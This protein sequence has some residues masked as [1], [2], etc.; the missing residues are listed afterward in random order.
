MEAEVE[1]L[2]PDDLIFPN[3]KGH[4]LGHDNLVKRRFLPLFNRQPTV[5]R[6]NWH[7]LRHFAV[8]C[9]IEERL[10]PKTVQTFA[11][12]PRYR[13]PWT[14]TGTCSQ[15]TTTAKRWTRLP[16]DCSINWG[17]RHSE[18]ENVWRTE[19]FIHVPSM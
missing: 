7:G 11:G 12:M 16:K 9:W 6:F 10:A 18:P 1:V 13:S 17:Y 14:A 15:A 8:S 3:R 5:E 19:R 4:H 2:Q